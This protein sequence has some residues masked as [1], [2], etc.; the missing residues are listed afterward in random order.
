MFGLFSGAAAE[1]TNESLLEWKK[2]FA[3]EEANQRTADLQERQLG[4]QQAQLDWDKERQRLIDQYNLGVIE[5]G[6]RERFA[7]TTIELMKDDRT[8]AEQRYT[9]WRSLSDMGSMY[10]PTAEALLKDRLMVTPREGLSLLNQ[11]A[12][13][14][15]GDMF[16]RTFV[17]M[18]ATAVAQSQGWDQEQTQDYVDN[19]MAILD[20]LESGK[21]QMDQALLDEATLK[22]NQLAATIEAT[23]A[24]TALTQTQ[25][26][27]IA[28]EL[29]WK[30]EDR[31]YELRI[32]ASQAGLLET[33]QFVEAFKANKMPEE[34]EAQNRLLWAEISKAENAN[35][36]FES[37]FKYQVRQVAAA[38]Q[39]S[40]EEARYLVATSGIRDAL[41][42][43]ELDRVRATTDLINQQ[44]LSE[45]ANTD[46]L[47]GQVDALSVEQ[48][49]TKV[50]IIGALVESGNSALL[51]ELAPDLLA[52]IVGEDRVA[53]LVD[54]LGSIASQ[55]LE[56]DQKLA[57]ANATMAHWQAEYAEET[58][59]AR[60]NQ[61]D[62]ESRLAIQQADTYMA[63]REWNRYLQEQGLLMDQ[64]RTKAYIASLQPVAMKGGSP[65]NTIDVLNAVQ[66][67]TGW[68][69]GKIAEYR[70]NII[71]AQT[72]LAE[73]RSLVS[74][75]GSVNTTSELAMK[76]GITSAE[77]VAAVV[78]RMEARVNALQDNLVSG[79]QQIISGGMSRGMFFTAADLGF[80]N[81]DPLFGRAWARMGMIRT[82]DS[83]GFTDPVTGETVPGSPVTSLSAA[84]RE[85][86]PQVQTAILDWLGSNPGDSLSDTFGG[87]YGLL[88]TLQDRFGAAVM[89][90][91]G[92][93]SASALAE[94]M[95][96]M[97]EQY[98][99]NSAALQE[100]S[101]ALGIDTSTRDGRN[102]LVAQSQARIDALS[103]LRRE[104]MQRWG[105]S[106]QDRQGLTQA[107][108]TLLPPGAQL[109]DGFNWWTDQFAGQSQQQILDAIDAAIGSYTNYQSGAL[110]FETR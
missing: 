14:K 77:D 76:Y 34:W 101:Q 86:A 25:T 30:A 87:A 103:S 49:S 79:Y 70:T 74:P 78:G 44:V 40:E 50:G 32:L 90:E 45:K 27:A 73:V 102:Q 64:D 80:A 94:K 47:W 71:D 43:G 61:A 26:Q 15:P 19:Y 95:A 81:D 98:G 67:S 52:G 13:A 96:P 104:V 42:Q 11:V 108:Q 37:T 2:L 88:S 60:V 85:A 48:T 28:T 16:D 89:D 82:D 29:G 24:N 35:Q 4:I 23:E 46:L 10:A 99:Q 57:A 100:G 31:P 7:Q 72:E 18:S 51:R 109:S 69:T 22:N 56:S 5:R 91:L 55:N 63:D 36:L 97:R 107:I 62:A 8:S 65:T 12:N 110:Y 75:N 58:F 93:T 9:Y 21:E 68:S 17:Q 20:G 39:I 66:D 92:F 59:V 1:K 33:Q 84:A 3:L 38:A 83:A 105:G 41:A 106:F 53:G 6:E 54:S